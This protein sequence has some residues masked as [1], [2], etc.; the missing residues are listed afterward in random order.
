[1]NVKWGLPTEGTL[2]DFVTMKPG[3]NVYFFMNR[4]VYGIGEVLEL[5]DGVTVAENFK[6]ATSVDTVT[7]ETIAGYQVDSIIEGKV[8]R[9]RFAFK[10]APAF[11]EDGIDIDDLLM[12]NPD[13]FRSLRVFWKRTFIK[14]DD[15]ENLAFMAALLRRNI[16]RISSP[17]AAS[18]FRFGN[19]V[20]PQVPK[21][22]SDRADNHG[23]LGSEMLLE[24]GLLYQ[25][26]HHDSETESVFG[27]W[28]YL[29]H[30]V[31]ASPSKPVDYMDKIDVFGYRYIKGYKPII[32]KYLVVELKKGT[33]TGDDITQVMKYVD[34]V[35]DEYAHGD[36]STITAFLVAHE[37]DRDSVMKM[38]E[39]AERHYVVGRRPAEAKTWQEL[40]FVTYK[41]EADGHLRFE[42]LHIQEDS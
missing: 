40:S 1:M 42:L 41:V 31:N 10:P 38:F 13:A 33:A 7:D 26:S 8:K 20:P 19:M 9:W 36:Y 32:E 16:D 35:R 2:G 30:Q 15:E 39:T 29:S 4:M 28:D 21:L 6:G 17:S 5:A 3:D 11:F 18:N 12:S 14:L 37:F 24:D 25:L 23:S 34:W 27:A 22:L